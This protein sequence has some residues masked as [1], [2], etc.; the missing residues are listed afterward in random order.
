LL[1]ALTGSGITANPTIH[2]H[3]NNYR[4]SSR[5]ANSLNLD[6]ATDYIGDHSWIGKSILFCSRAALWMQLAG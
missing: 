4:Q 5:F 1:N 2:L 6:A 3:A